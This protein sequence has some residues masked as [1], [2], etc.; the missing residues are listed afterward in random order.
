MPYKRGDMVEITGDHS[1]HGL[2][3]G[4]AVRVDARAADAPDGEPVYKVT[5]DVDGRRTSRYAVRK[6]LVKRR[7]KK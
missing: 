3:K 5:L 1:R 7:A 4:A 2:P 6:D